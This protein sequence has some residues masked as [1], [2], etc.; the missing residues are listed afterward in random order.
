MQLAHLLSLL[1]LFSLSVSIAY[2]PNHFF[3]FFL[4]SLPFLSD[5]R[6]YVCSLLTYLTFKTLFCFLFL[7]HPG[8]CAEKWLC[9]ALAQQSDTPFL[10]TGTNGSAPVGW[11]PV[12]PFFLLHLITAYYSWLFVDGKRCLSTSIS[13]LDFRFRVV[14]LLPLKGKVTDFTGVQKMTSREN[15]ALHLRL[16]H[17]PQFFCFWSGQNVSYN[18]CDKVNLAFTTT[19][20]FYRLNEYYL[21]FFSILAF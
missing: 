10:C 13:W 3:F 14:I 4:K 8:F 16:K 12:F 6:H 1:C 2:C 5:F 17:L 19:F 7:S 9:V 15:F 18:Y 11:L 20:K 21:L